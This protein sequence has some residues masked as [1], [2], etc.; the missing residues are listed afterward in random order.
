M[1]TT[2]ASLF[3]KWRRRSEPP[4]PDR[5]VRGLESRYLAAAL[6]KFREKAMTPRLYRTLRRL[7]KRLSRASL[8]FSYGKVDPRG[9]PHLHCP[10]CGM[11]VLLCETLDR[12]QR[13]QISAVRNEDAGQVRDLLARW[14][15]L[16]EGDAKPVFLHICREPGICHNCEQPIHRGSLMCPHCLAVTLDW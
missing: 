16:D 12:E 15:A 4:L 7:P 8:D 6:K 11:V 13:Q 3:D 2:L 10:Q 5:H 14:L 1:L 9:R